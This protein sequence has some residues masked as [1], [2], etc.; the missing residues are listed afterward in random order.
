[1]ADEAA[2]IGSMDGA[3]ATVSGLEAGQDS[4][5]ITKTPTM[6][7]PNVPSPT[8]L[9]TGGGIQSHW[10]DIGGSGVQPSPTR[11]ETEFV[12]HDSPI[13]AGNTA[14]SD[15]G[16]LTLQELMDTCTNL[17]KQ[18]SLLKKELAQTK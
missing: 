13:L 15:E 14:R 7:T 3:G 11:E 16:R 12:P 8:R 9:G 1:M 17:T 18:V 5:N 4:A 2:I 10:H 6:A